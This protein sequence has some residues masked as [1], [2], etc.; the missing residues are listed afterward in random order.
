MTLAPNNV[1]GIRQAKVATQRSVRV[2]VIHPDSSVDVLLLTGSDAERFA[3][4]RRLA[5]DCSLSTILISD[6]DGP[7]AIGW[8]DD[9]GADKGLRLN[10]VASHLAER[11]VVGPMVVTGLGRGDEAPISSVHDG[12]RHVLRR[13]ARAS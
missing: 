6:H 10:A 5:G 7:A 1:V 11:P 9:R 3:K 2:S 8:V 12:L 13:M 4:V